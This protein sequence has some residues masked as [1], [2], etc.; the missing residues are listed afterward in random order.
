MTR[1]RTAILFAALLAAG[2]ATAAAAP[3]DVTRVSVTDAGAEANAVSE[4]T[5]VSADGRFVAFVSAA[6]LTAA[7]TGGKKQ[8]YVR[9]RATGRTVLASAG[10]AG[11][12]NGD[13]DPGDSFNS[14]I[15]ISSDGR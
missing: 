6:Q 2:T 14:K 10:A 5:A 9:D 15:D 12:A 7:P 8:L 1:R 3:G 4:A 13:V 11:P